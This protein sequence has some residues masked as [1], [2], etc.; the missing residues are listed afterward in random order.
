[1]PRAI[2]QALLPSHLDLDKAS[3]D[4]KRNSLLFLFLET[5]TEHSFCQERNGNRSHQN[6]HDLSYD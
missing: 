1:M 3:G 2:D 4:L 5:Q 6:V